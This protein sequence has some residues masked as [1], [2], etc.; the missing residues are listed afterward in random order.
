M[1]PALLAPMLSVLATGTAQPAVA[2]T[3]TVVSAV[4]SA[5]TPN[6]T[7]GAVFAFAQVGSTMVVGGSFTKLAAAGTTSPTFAHPDVAAFSTSDGAISSAFA[8]TINGEVDALLPGPAAN[9]VYVG[10]QFTTID[11][12]STRVALLNVSTGAIASGWTSPTMNGS[13]SSLALA[14]GQLLVGGYFTTVGGASH[15]GLVSLNA[16]TGAVTS[17]A[18]LSFTGH[19]NYGTK[20]D[21]SARACA[22]APVGPRSMSVNPQGTELA[23]IGNFIK[24]GSATREQIALINLTASSAT[25]DTGWNSAVYSAPCWLQ[26]FDSYV[27][28]VSFS[29]DGTFFA[30]TATGASNLS[31]VHDINTDGTYAPCDAVIKFNTSQHGADVKPVW[32]DRTGNDTLVG[33]AVTNSA[34]YVGGHQR[35][36]NNYQGHDSPHE[37]AVPRPG[38]GAVDV[39]NGMPLAWNPGRNPRGIGAYALYPTSDGLWVGSDTNYIGNQKYLREKMAFFPYA[40]GYSPPSAAGT[41]TLPGRLYAA[42]ATAATA[43]QPDRLTLTH[44]T[45]SSSSDP[46][47]VPSPVSWSK[48]R[49]AFYLDGDVYYGRGGWLFRRSFDGSTFGPAVKLDP[50]DD[51]TWATIQTGSGQTYRGVPSGLKGELPGVTSLFFTN[52]R[53]YYTRSGDQHL[54]YRYFEPDDGAVG[55]EELTAPGTH[56]WSNVA[57]AVLAGKTLFF[58]NR[59]TGQLDAIKWTGSQSRGSAVVVSPSRGWASRGMFMLPAAGSGTVPTAKLSRSCNSATA[60]CTFTATPW[61]D[62]DGGPTTYSWSFGDGVAKS[63]SRATV[64]HRYTKRGTFNVSL[65]VSDAGGGA[66]AD[67]A[68]VSITAPIKTI[69]EVSAASTKGT[70]RKVPVRIPKHLSAGDEL[71]MV[72]TSKSGGGTPKTRSGWHTAGSVSVGGLRS[73]V[74]TRRV[75]SARVSGGRTTIKFRRPGPSEIVVSAYSGVS[76][77]PVAQI[78]KRTATAGSAH[79]TPALKNL[80]VGQ[81]AVWVWSQ[82]SKSPGHW[83][84]ARGSKW[85]VGSQTAGRPS[86]AA[87]I[88]DSA[89]SVSGSRA[90]RTAKNTVAATGAVT[91]SIVLT[92]QVG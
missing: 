18:R 50:Y 79:P 59:T 26:D 87:L 78:L 1:L 47:D 44:V 92:P 73:S 33:L 64:T 55:A 17:Y 32:Q 15:K 86:V 21:P 85:R 23:V 74:F 30:V 8:P 82:R 2:A 9:E 52:G 81:W 90:G 6:A 71:V 7:D 57:G 11:G 45:S 77:R 41:P 31:K 46:T 39:V 83:S 68:R 88:A 5:D 28:N 89:R 42:G 16:T 14:H 29:P 4:P 70:H 62:P 80:S 13:V 37:G 22:D 76:S 38:L 66:A 19:H 51:P 43:A 72:T 67:S 58:G 49:G 36:M 25:L 3:P 24:V 75:T 35:W 10:G 53:L 12:V 27:R 20:C 65:D 91:W 84:P 48:A 69:G 40:G 61:T 60:T 63:G 54:Y 34:I 56:S